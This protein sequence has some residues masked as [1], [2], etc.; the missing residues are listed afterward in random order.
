MPQRAFC[1]ASFFGSQCDGSGLVGSIGLWF[2]RPT[3]KYDL[4]S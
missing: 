4:W 3:L 2:T 1:S